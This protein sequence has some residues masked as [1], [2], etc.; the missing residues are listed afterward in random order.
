ML[1]VNVRES[2]HDRILSLNIIETFFNFVLNQSY[3]T[4][5]TSYDR[6]HVSAKLNHHQVFCK[7]NKNIVEQQ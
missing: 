5:I 6:L 1:F 3:T 7:N 2:L 4:C